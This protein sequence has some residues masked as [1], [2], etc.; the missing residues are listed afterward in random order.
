ML[1]HN[2]T[3]LQI[4]KKRRK[5]IM[6]IAARMTSR[7]RVWKAVNHQVPDRVPIDLG[8]MKASGIAV[9]AYHKLKQKLGIDTPTKVLDPR[10]MIALVED[11]VLQRL[12]GDVV[13]LD[14]S[15][16]LGMVRPDR[17]WLPRRMFDGTEALFPPGT[18]IAEDADGNWILLGVDGSPSSF[19]MPRTATTSTISRS[20]RARIEPEAFRPVSDIPDEHLRILGQYGRTLYENTDYAILGWGF[21]ICSWV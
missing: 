7:E 14:L 20:I 4:R 21:G 13:P 18:S 11:E 19:R 6:T 3:D 16:L 5:N 1:K 17:E 2:L 8:G 15:V 9:S 10:F 12:H